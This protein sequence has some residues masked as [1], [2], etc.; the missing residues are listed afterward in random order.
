MRELVDVLLREQAAQIGTD[1]SALPSWKQL[2]ASLAAV[3]N[4]R[5][6]STSGWGALA[7]TEVK[8]AALVARGDSTADIARSLLLSGRTVR[9]Y[10][11][12]I[13]TKLDARSRIDIAREALRQGIAD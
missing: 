5:L 7:P 12:H 2:P 4:D 3:L 10:I 8:I 6:S 1:V 9:T 13:M 11:S